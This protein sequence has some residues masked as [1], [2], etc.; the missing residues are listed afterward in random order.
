MP[1]TPSGLPQL[2]AVCPAI[3]DQLT[4]I[5]VNTPM[6][7]RSMLGTALALRSEANRAGVVMDIPVPQDGQLRPVQIMYGQRGSVSTVITEETPCVDWSGS[8]TPNNY[9]EYIT[10]DQFYF[11]SQQLQFNVDQMRELCEM[12]DSFMARNI[13][14]TLD[15]LGQTINNQ[16]ISSLFSAAGTYSNGTNSGTTPASLALLGTIATNVESPQPVKW[17]RGFTAEVTRLR[18][19]GKPLVIGMGDVFTYLNSIEQGGINMGGVDVRR[20]G[21]VTYFADSAVETALANANYFLSM[22]AGAAQLITQNRFVGDF[23]KTAG[24]YFRYGTITDPVLGLTY[25]FY[26]KFDSDCQKYN[27]QISLHYLPYALFNQTD[28]WPAGDPLYGNTYIHQW[29]AA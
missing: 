28:M 15:S 18:Y 8:V 7:T 29:N 11:V 20:A 22:Q 4:S 25:D 6:Q 1:N 19:A 9:S 10:P 14:A 2:D 17:T 13:N 16:C 21:N 5:A 12:P 26:V 27:V 3:N 23:V 24:D